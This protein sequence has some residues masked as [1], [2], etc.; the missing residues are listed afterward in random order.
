MVMEYA[1]RIKQARLKDM[2]TD[3]GI[4]QMLE[5]SVFGL[6]STGS[7]QRSIRDR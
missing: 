3:A 6:A 5:L 7:Y 2:T 4:Q 1:A